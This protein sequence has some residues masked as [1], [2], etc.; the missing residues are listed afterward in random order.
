MQSRPTEQNQEASEYHLDQ[1]EASE[2][3][4]L[5]N[6]PHQ[7]RSIENLNFK[8]E[9]LDNKNQ[10]DMAILDSSIPARPNGSCR[11]TLSMVD[12]SNIPS[13]TR[14]RLISIQSLCDSLLRRSPKS[15]LKVFDESKKA[16]NRPAEP[17]YPI[18]MSNPHILASSLYNTSPKRSLNDNLKMFDGS[19]TTLTMNMQPIGFTGTIGITRTTSKT[20]MAMNTIVQQKTGHKWTIE[21]SRNPKNP[22]GFHDFSKASKKI[23][24]MRKYAGDLGK[25]QVR[26]IRKFQ[27][28][29]SGLSSAD[30]TFLNM[31]PVPMSDPLGLN[32]ILMEN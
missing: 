20:S 7:D 6:G 12:M 30:Q 2:H 19:Q 15:D 23:Q 11:K 29:Q 8:N 22:K 18:Q 10:I 5:K 28:D 1:D 26:K 4:Q 24:K 32:E 31:Y 13:G 9:I 17:F 27:E 16:S 3:E 14:H 21:A 25:K